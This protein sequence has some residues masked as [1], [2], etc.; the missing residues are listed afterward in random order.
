MI[1]GC[2]NESIGKCVDVEYRG[3][4]MAFCEE[5]SGALNRRKREL[6]CCRPCSRDKHTDICQECS[7]DILSARFKFYVITGIL[8]CLIFGILVTLVHLLL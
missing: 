2:Q 6:L 1:R 3:C 7:N 4:T 5:H 8:S